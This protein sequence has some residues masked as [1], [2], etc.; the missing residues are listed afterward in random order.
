MEAF[1][2]LESEALFLGMY[3]ASVLFIILIHESF[4]SKKLENLVTPFALIV[5]PSDGIAFW[6]SA[7]SLPMF[8]TEKL[9]SL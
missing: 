2:F 6:S 5:A 3:S 9:L 8:R 1:G 4:F 7:L